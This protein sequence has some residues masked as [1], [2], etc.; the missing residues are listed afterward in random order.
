MCK[1]CAEFT[2]KCTVCSDTRENLPT[3]KCKNGF[4]DDKK[5]PIC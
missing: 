5:T 4:A 2:N 1:E 3:C